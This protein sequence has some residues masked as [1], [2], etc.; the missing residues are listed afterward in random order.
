MAYTF[1]NNPPITSGDKKANSHKDW[2]EDV[3]DNIEAIQY[4]LWYHAD[5][6]KGH[7][8]C[9]VTG[10]S[11]AATSP[12]SMRVT[13]AAGHA[14]VDYVPFRKSAAETTHDFVAP[15]S[16]DRIDTIAVDATTG[17]IV[18]HK[19]AENVTPSAPSVSE[20]EVK[21]AELYLR[22]GMTA[23]YDS[24]TTGEGYITDSRV[25]AGS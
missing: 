1:P 2:L 18:I 19:G 20:G 7:T 22:P 12:E 15:S 3:V 10:L 17:L 8:S 5:N 14:F 16:A 24:D 21:V 11:C 4:A 25:I 9:V 23:I 13:V 6:G